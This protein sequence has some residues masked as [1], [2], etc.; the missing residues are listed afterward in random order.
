M[1]PRHYLLVQLQP[2][3]QNVKWAAIKGDHIVSTTTENKKVGSRIADD[4]NRIA[5][6]NGTD[7]NLSAFCGRGEFKSISLARKL[8]VAPNYNFFLF[9]FIFFFFEGFT[10]RQVR[11]YIHLEV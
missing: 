2:L 4:H 6:K 11:K 5:T 3:K 10:Q 9:L 1:K 7:N 8:T